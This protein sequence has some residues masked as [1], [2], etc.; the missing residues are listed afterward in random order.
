MLLYFQNYQ[1]DQKD[2]TEVFKELI[3]EDLICKKIE[4]IR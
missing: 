4:F 2:S 1:S 3:K